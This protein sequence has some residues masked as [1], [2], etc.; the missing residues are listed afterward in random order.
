MFY[1]GW[2]RRMAL[3]L[4]TSYFSP[5]FAEK[6]DPAFRVFEPTGNTEPSKEEIQSERFDITTT[7]LGDNVLLSVLNG[8]IP[9]T[10]CYAKD[11]AKFVGTPT[12]F[13]GIT[14][15]WFVLVNFHSEAPFNDYRNFDPVRDRGKRSLCWG[16][17]YDNVISFS[18]GLQTLNDILERL[19]LLTSWSGGTVRQFVS[20]IF[21]P[22]GSAVKFMI[23][24]AAPQEGRLSSK[25][26]DDEA[27]GAESRPGFGMQVRWATL[28]DGT[29]IL[30]LPLFQFADHSREGKRKGGGR[31]NKKFS[32]SSVTSAVL[33]VYKRNFPKGGA[34]SD[35]VIGI[36]CNP[37][38]R[39]PLAE[40]VNPWDPEELIRYYAEKPY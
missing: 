4:G 7:D 33:D 35:D 2:L 10:F 9:Y 11:H 27:M 34:I 1:L 14:G 3:I 25:T 5:S 32:L 19:A 13:E 20:F 18:G 36:L 30:T 21:V 37:W 17:P 16:T 6:T 31:G 28:P 22:P 23:G 40:G 8:A 15:K 12:E 29:I 38:E 26:K 24:Y 39:G